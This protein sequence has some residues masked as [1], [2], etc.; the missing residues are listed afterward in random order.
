MNLG[1]VLAAEGDYEGAT[2]R[3][4]VVLE[5]AKKSAEGADH[6]DVAMALNNVG[7]SLSLEDKDEEALPYVIEALEM[8]TRLYGEGHPKTASSVATVGTVNAKLGRASEAEDYLQRALTIFVGAAGE[9][10]PRSIAMLSELGHLHLANGAAKKALPFL[11]RAVAARG[12]AAST[13]LAKDRLALAQALWEASDRAA[14]GEQVIA[15]Q[16]LLAGLEDAD[17]VSASLKQW[18]RDR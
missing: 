11:R 5:R 2:G 16:T 9:T 17:S 1:I 7:E 15:L 14:A 12:D 10:H 6:P 18:L 3:F 4:L 13:D 8:K